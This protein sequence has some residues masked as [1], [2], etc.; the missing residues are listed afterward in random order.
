MS[1]PIPQSRGDQVRD[2]IQSLTDS[3]FAQLRSWCATDEE[4]RRA[5]DRGTRLV[6]PALRQS[7]FMGTPPEVWEP[8]PKPPAMTD[9]PD[10]E[11]WV[12]LPDDHA[13]HDG[14]RYVNVLPLSEGLNCDMPGATQWWQPAPEEVTTDEDGTA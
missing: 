6:Y 2:L 8:A 7:G 5:A 10:P 3:E 1:I 4:Q 11:T 13:T 9:L 14:V 12:W